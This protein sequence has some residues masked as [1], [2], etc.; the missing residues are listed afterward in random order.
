LT[1]ETAKARPVVQL[2][3]NTRTCFSSG[4]PRANCLRLEEGKIANALP[5]SAT[6][7]RNI[8]KNERAYKIPSGSDNDLD[9]DSVIAIVH[10]RKA[11]RRYA[12][13]RCVR[14][15][16]GADINYRNEP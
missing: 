4:A 10:D 3:L 13:L 15:I 7:R 1:H 8:R 12:E 11:L 14:E 2:A 16:T 6:S 9:L 5:K